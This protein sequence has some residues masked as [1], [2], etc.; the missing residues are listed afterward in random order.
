MGEQGRQD[1]HQRRDT[2]QR[3][4]YRR[5]D[6]NAPVILA[7]GERPP[8]LDLGLGPEDE[9]DQHGRDREIIDAGDVADEAEAAASIEAVVEDT[10]HLITTYHQILPANPRLIRR[11]VNTWGMLT[12]LRKHVRHSEED[13]TLIRAA[14]FF[15]MFPTLTDELLSSKPLIGV[16]DI[17]AKKYDGPWK[18]PD[19]LRVLQTTD[20]EIDEA[21]LKPE[22]FLEPRVLA[23]CY[24]RQC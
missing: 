24:G 4:G 21:N 15:V 5:A 9:A 17:L 11:V 8:Q 7:D 10:R 16:K 23:R 6:Q 19:V 12:A 2:E 3:G 13:D 20:D 22:D 14:V 1:E 18:H